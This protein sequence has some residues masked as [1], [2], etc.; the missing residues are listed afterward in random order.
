MQLRT[1][2]I[3][4][5]QAA[6]S[7]LCPLS[8]DAVVVAVAKRSIQYPKQAAGLVIGMQSVSVVN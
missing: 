6:A 8:A 2:V 3:A 7:M 5:A 1:R 4:F